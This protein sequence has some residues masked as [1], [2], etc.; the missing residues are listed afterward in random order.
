MKRV[1]TSCWLHSFCGTSRSIFHHAPVRLIVH[2]GA[3]TGKS[4]VIRIAAIHAE[5]I[6]RQ[7]GS[8]PNK[9]R[10]LILGPTGKAASLIG[11]FP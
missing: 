8:H 9:P 11:K 10:V 2:G 3:G 4:A 1:E 6:L 5:K 7:S